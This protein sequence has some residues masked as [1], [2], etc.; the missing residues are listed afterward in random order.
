MTFHLGGPPTYPTALDYNSVMDCY[1][2]PF[3]LNPFA[4]MHTDIE[5]RPSPVVKV[6]KVF[7]L[8]VVEMFVGVVVV[9]CAA[10]FEP[11]P[12]G[13]PSLIGFDHSYLNRASNQPW[14]I[15]QSFERN[16]GLGVAGLVGFVILE[17]KC[18]P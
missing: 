17:K 18:A 6:M 5:Q 3:L 8:V 2:R 16:Q 15:V 11:S 9:V 13:W 4:T 7:V 14:R 1:T 12:V 10:E